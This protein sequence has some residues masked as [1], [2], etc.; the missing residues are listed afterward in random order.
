MSWEVGFVAR[1]WLL[2]ERE[3]ERERWRYF[4]NDLY[5]LY[6]LCL[7]SMK[8]VF[9]GILAYTNKNLQKTCHN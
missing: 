7:N 1:F 6:V 8:V 3:R 9:F 2:L 5:S 4:E